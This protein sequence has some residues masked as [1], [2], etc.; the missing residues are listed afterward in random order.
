MPSQ[1]KLTYDILY[2]FPFSSETKRMGIVIRNRTT[3][4]ITFYLKGADTIM[5]DFINNR[6][7]K[8]FIDEEC[9]DLSMTGLRTLVF[10]V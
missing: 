1:T 2:T 7:K 4:E 3:E 9:K 10:G 5:K 8:G 6:Q